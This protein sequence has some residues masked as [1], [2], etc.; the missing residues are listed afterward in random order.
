M[1]VPSSVARAAG[2][3][4]CQDSTVC[5]VVNVVDV[6]DPLALKPA[7]HAV[8]VG[9]DAYGLAYRASSS[10]LYVSNF[11]DATNPARATG[12]V[13]VVK[14]NADG[15]GAQQQVYK[16][17]RAPTGI[18]LSPD[19]S[20]LAVANSD[21]DSV[22][23]LSIGADGSIT[24]AKTVDVRLAHDAPLGTAPTAVA[25][26]PDGRLL[27]A[28]SGIDALE[29]LDAGGNP[30][31]QRVSVEYRGRIVHVHVPATYV[32]TA[33]Y[34]DALAVGVRPGGGSRVVVA[35]LRGDGS[36]PGYYGQLQ[37]LVG[38]STEGT[39]SVID[40]PTDARALAS[41]LNAYT[42]RV[43]RDDELAP[44]FAA[45]PDPAANACVGGTKP[46][47]GTYATGILCA[48][49][50][51]LL[52]PKQVHVVVIDAENKTFDSYFGDMKSTLTNADA[53]PLFTEYGDAVTT[54]QHNLA[55]SFTLSDSFWNEGAEASTLGHD[56]LTG[57]YT[58]V[59]RE[60]TWG[61]E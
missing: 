17:G 47:G 16:V 20:T 8:S 35:N 39:L 1:S 24:G 12:T 19:R 11:A 51:G 7:V 38:T 36:G 60:I 18:A 42:A 49:Q 44:V 46:G 32:P 30:I 40:V 13:S 61:Q 21:S 58:T 10:T 27:V 31:P 52:D 26:L 3:A 53:S 48:A 50:K 6:S 22:S 29:V 15:T 41:E 59:S 33:W 28:L 54:N 9:R 43:V 2:G 23:L 45:L 55:K 5:S 56:W 14:M 37:P 57:G 4:A 34:P 25:Y